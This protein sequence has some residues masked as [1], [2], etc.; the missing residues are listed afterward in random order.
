MDPQIFKSFTKS[1]YGDFEV[2]IDKLNEN[3]PF[4]V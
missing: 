2:K 3:L 1:R 4:E